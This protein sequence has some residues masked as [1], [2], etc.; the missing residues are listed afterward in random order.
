MAR[1]NMLEDRNHEL[2]MKLLKVKQ[3]AAKW[4]EMEEGLSGEGTI[5]G[6]VKWIRGASQGTLMRV[7]ASEIFEIVGYPEE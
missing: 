1:V 7:C 5:A 4:K 2:L 3:T 6:P